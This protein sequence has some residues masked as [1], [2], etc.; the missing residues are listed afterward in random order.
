MILALNKNLPI[1]ILPVRLALWGYAGFI[2]GHVFFSIVV[3]RM[4][5]PPCSTRLSVGPSQ[6]SGLAHLLMG[7]AK[8]RFTI[9]KNLPITILPSR[10]ALRGRPVPLGTLVFLHCVRENVIFSLFIFLNRCRSLD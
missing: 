4:D 7:W 2:K 6:L 5:G 1:I 9:N 3:G 10:L 8:R